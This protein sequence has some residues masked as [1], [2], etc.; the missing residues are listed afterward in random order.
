[1][2]RA[3]DIFKPTSNHELVFIE[4]VFIELR[5]HRR[6]VVLD[7]VT[8]RPVLTSSTLVIKGWTGADGRHMTK[9]H[10][11]V[12]GNEHRLR[13]ILCEAQT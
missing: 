11:C 5:L 1:M 10:A 2:L 3:L 7:L 4:L 8:C 6:F 13:A 9:G 12:D